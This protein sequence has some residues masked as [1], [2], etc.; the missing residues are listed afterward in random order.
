MAINKSILQPSGVS[1]SYWNVDKLIVNAKAQNMIVELTGYL[2]QE[3]YQ[4]GSAAI[5]TMTLGFG[6]SDFVSMISSPNIIAAFYA[7]IMALPEFSGSTD[8]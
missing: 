4:A 7:A 8:C 3:S 2:S 1:A 5:T 6:A